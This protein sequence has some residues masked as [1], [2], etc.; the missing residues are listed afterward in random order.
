MPAVGVI[1]FRS[2]P[3]RHVVEITSITNAPAAQGGT[4]PVQGPVARRAAE[5][6]PLSQ[7]ELERAAQTQSRATWQIRLRYFDGLT[8]KHRIEWVERN[9][10]RRF[11]I[12]SV[13]DTDARR[14]EHVVLATEAA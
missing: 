2:G 11:E 10:R 12:E 7:R 13:I 3:L 9:V 14:R 4:K 5:V 1:P 8:P 6:R